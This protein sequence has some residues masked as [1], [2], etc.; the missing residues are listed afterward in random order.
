MHSQTTLKND[1]WQNYQ[2]I[3]DHYN[4][5]SSQYADQWISANDGK[6]IASG[7]SIKEVERK[8]QKIT[9]RNRLP[10]M[11]LE[12]GVHIYGIVTQLRS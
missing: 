12:K 11:F 6:V 7:R 4:E 9:G 3:L 2:W 1:F 5:L 10:I 8:V